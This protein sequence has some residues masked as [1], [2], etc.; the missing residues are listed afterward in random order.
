MQLLSSSRGDD[1][2]L[3]TLARIKRIKLLI[4]D[5][6]GVSPLKASEAR[7]LLEIVEDRTNNASL[8]ITSQLP[9]ADWYSHLHNP[10]IADAILDRI[11][12][13]PIKLNSRRNLN[14]NSN[15][16]KKKNSKDGFTLQFYSLIHPNQSGNMFVKWVETLSEIYIQK[17]VRED[18]FTELMDKIH[19]IDT[20]QISFG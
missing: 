3:K 5:D 4:L 6:F 14:A 8:I 19:S 2:Y 18:L 9:I 15:R 1:E 12:T 10:T 7:D 17:L 13:M 11:V 20:T 16:R